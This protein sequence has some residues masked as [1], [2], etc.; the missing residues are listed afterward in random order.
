MYSLG[1]VW[2]ECLWDSITYDYRQHVIRAQFN[3]NGNGNAAN[4]NGANAKGWLSSQQ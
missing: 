3:A 4:A 2:V 1:Y